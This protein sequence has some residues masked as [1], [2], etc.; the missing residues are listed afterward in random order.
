[1]PPLWCLPEGER[2]MVNILPGNWQGAFESES[3]GITQHACRPKTHILLSLSHTHTHTHTHTQP[4]SFTPTTHNPQPWPQF[5]NELDILLPPL[6]F[7]LYPS[8]SLSLSQI[9][10]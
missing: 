9:V 10:S 4:Y 8:L 7:S 6:S 2:V 3:Q 5:T 1:M